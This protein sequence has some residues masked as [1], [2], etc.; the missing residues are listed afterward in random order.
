LRNFD[1]LAEGKESRFVVDGNLIN[2]QQPAIGFALTVTS[3][4][5]YQIRR[6][7][8]TEAVLEER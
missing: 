7:G 8:T 5:A 3:T 2:V 1:L 4:V 6:S